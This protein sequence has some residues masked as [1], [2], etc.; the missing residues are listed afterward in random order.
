MYFL[1]FV[2]KAYLDC[3][4][5]LL[6]KLCADLANPKTDL[7]SSYKVEWTHVHVIKNFPESELHH[8]LLGEICA[9]AAVGV[10]LQCKRE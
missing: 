10:E 9:Q 8:Y 5:Q 4:I 3:L 7:L 2:E 6:P 1:Y